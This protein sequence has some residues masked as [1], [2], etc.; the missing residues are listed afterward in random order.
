MY[1]KIQIIWDLISIRYLKWKYR[2]RLSVLQQN[3][4]RHFQSTLRSS[5]FYSE[6][7]KI[8]TPIGDYPIMNKSSFMNNFDLINTEGITFKQANK[9]ALEAELSRNFSPMLGNVSV[10]LSSG[11]SGNRSVFLSSDKERAQWVAT[12]LDRVIGLSFKHRTVAFFLRANNN[13]Y[14]AVQSNLLNFEFFDLLQHINI[15]IKR[16]NELNPSILVAQPSALL[17]LANYHRNGQLTIT[18]EKIISIAEVLYPEDRTILENSFGQ[19]IHQIY[20]CTEGFLASTCKEG[21]LHFNEDFLVIEKKYIDDDRSRFHPIITD[22][23]RVTQPIVRF[24]LNDIIIEKKNC[25]CGSQQLAIEQIEGRSD[26]IL[27]FEENNVIVKIFPDFFRRAIIMSDPD[28]IDYTL[29]MRE[30]N[31]LELFVNGID[32]HFKNAEK[33]IK[34]LL[35]RNG[36]Y[37]VEI[38]RAQNSHH[39]IGFKLRRIINA[40]R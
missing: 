39:E 30:R 35:N 17:E 37:N 25:L 22:L 29:L 16:L 7:S 27:I 19:K 24:E 2:N 11:T 40:T 12:I 28:I 31:V 18:P 8:N 1:F 5:P 21:T 9:V 3:R 26:D 33:A 34:N 4:W 10:G 20:Q 14:S 6:L 36:I 13:L 23:L 32:S 38:M 15:H